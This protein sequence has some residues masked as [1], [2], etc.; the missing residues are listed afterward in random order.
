VS[1]VIAIV[2]GLGASRAAAAEPCWQRVI[3]AWS[4]GTLDASFPPGCYRTAL[5]RLPEDVALYSTAQDDINRELLAAIARHPASREAAHAPASKS[6][7]PALAF[8]AGGAAVLLAAGV[9][10]NRL[11]ARRRSPR[12]GSRAAH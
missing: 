7:V 6:G 12:R 1:T 10:G 3:S 5:D 8:A 9:V 11:L 2:L 4:A